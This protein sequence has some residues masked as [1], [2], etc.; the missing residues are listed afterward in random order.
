MKQYYIIIKVLF[1]FALEVWFSI[2]QT[3]RHLVRFNKTSV[4]LPDRV[5][6]SRLM[7]SALISVNSYLLLIEFHVLRF[8]HSI[9][10][11]IIWYQDSI[12]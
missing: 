4:A 11:V 3:L 9:Q 7:D 8:I 10:R 12:W 5:V 1:D 2:D 6:R